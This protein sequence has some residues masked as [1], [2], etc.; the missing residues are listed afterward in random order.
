[1]FNF[2]SRLTTYRQEGGS[3]STSG[4]KKQARSRVGPAQRPQASLCRHRRRQISLLSKVYLISP[5]AAMR[6]PKKIYDNY[7]DKPSY[8][9][10]PIYILTQGRPRGRDERKKG[11]VKLKLRLTIV[12]QNYNF[13]Q[14]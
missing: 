3:C 7:G 9:Q 10:R 12:R 5:L 11:K 14:F 4:R 13:N 2:S 6:R 8:E 1:M